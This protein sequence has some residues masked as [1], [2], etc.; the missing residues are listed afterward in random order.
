MASNP[1]QDI[2]NEVLN[3]V[4][5]SQESVIDAIKTWVETVQ[6]ISPKVPAMDMPFADK[7]PKPE[8]IVASAYDFAEQ[9]LASQRRF[10]EEVLKATSA[11][12]PGTEGSTK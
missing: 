11:L 12:T 9:L 10:A 4:R 7:L 6:S 3:T 5:K 8:E 1:T 2:Q